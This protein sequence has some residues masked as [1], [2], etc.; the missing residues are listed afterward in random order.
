MLLTH[1]D[2]VK[3]FWNL[4][5]SLCTTWSLSALSLEPT[6]LSLLTLNTLYNSLKMSTFIIIYLSA[7]AASCAHEASRKDLGQIVLKCVLC[8]DSMLKLVLMFLT[9]TNLSIISSIYA[10]YFWSH[11]FGRLKFCSNG[12]IHAQYF[13]PRA[14]PLSFYWRVFSTVTFHC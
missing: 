9:R 8:L 4:S 14:I 12:Q 5:I 13:F 7:G 6:P 1:L 3:Y 11:Y 10:V 2:I